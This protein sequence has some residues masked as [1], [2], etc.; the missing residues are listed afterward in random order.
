MIGYFTASFACCLSFFFENC[1]FSTNS[2]HSLKRNEWITYVACSCRFIWSNWFGFFLLYF[3]EYLSV[4]NEWIFYAMHHSFSLLL[5]FS[6]DPAHPLSLYRSHWL[7]TVT[8]R[9][10]YIRR[11]LKY[12]YFSA[13]YAHHYTLSI[14][15]FIV[16]ADDAIVKC[17]YA[18]VQQTHENI[19]AAH[20]ITSSKPFSRRK[21]VET[22]LF[23]LVRHAETA[24]CRRT[25]NDLMAFSWQEKFDVIERTTNAF[26]CRHFVN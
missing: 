16:L 18:H 13:F 9:F 25:E 15:C 17:S 4:R 24:V 12:K 1:S 5:F 7:T 6:F 10:G 22:E 8:S 19:A 11:T 26:V 14:I 23:F 2:G 3:V 20:A 21:T